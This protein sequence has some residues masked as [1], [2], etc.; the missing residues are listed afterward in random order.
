MKCFP[1][2]SQLVASESQRQKLK[3]SKAEENNLLPKYPNHRDVAPTSGMRG[4]LGKDT[5]RTD[6][7]LFLSV[8]LFLSHSRLFPYDSQCGSR[9]FLGHN[10]IRLRTVLKFLISP[11]RKISGKDSDWIE[12]NHIFSRNTYL[13][14]EKSISPKE[15]K[16]KNVA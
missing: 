13:G 14:W 2:S 16:Q 10:L 7:L 8:C 11:L 1:Y 9:Q 6:T 4:C 12:R 15:R 3:L 5:V